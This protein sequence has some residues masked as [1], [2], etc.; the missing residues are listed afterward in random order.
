MAVARTIKGILNKCP[1]CN[2]LAVSQFRPF[3]SLRCSQIDLSNWLNEDYCIP[4]AKFED[5]DEER[6]FGENE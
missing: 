2:K 1:N 6:L 5:T 4:V 3:C